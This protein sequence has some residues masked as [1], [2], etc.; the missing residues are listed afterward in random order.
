MLPN[1]VPSLPHTKTHCL[2][3]QTQTFRCEISQSPPLS[4]TKLHPSPIKH[5]P[6]KKGI[7]Q[8]AHL[9]SFHLSWLLL[10]NKKLGYPRCKFSFIPSQIGFNCTVIKLDRKMARLCFTVSQIRISTEVISAVKVEL[11]IKCDG[12]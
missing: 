8:K 10:L 9:D 11:K 7:V 12:S 3:K 4:P 1:Q 5:C 2:R 6:W